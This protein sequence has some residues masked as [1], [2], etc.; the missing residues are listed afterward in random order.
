MES[1]G[2]SPL[3][4]LRHAPITSEAFTAALFSVYEKLCLHHARQTTSRKWQCSQCEWLLGKRDAAFGPGA[5][6]EKIPQS[7]P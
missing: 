5:F 2:R 7:C 4:I 6:S 3:R 1:E